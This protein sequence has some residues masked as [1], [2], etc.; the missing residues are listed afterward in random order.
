MCSVIGPILTGIWTNRSMSRE[1]EKGDKKLQILFVGACD[2]DLEE[3]Q[4][5]S[6][7]SG[8]VVLKINDMYFLCSLPRPEPQWVNLS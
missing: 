2:I 6:V 3:V 7:S 5:S 1:Y 4:P 8:V